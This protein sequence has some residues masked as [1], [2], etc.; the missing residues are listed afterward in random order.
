[1]SSTIGLKTI[2]WYFKNN[3]MTSQ[4]PS[5]YVIHISH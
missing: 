5:T 4:S 2:G 3:K 1:M